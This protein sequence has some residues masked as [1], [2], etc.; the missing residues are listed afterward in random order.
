MISIANH[1]QPLHLDAWTNH[2]AWTNP[3][4][5]TAMISPIYRPRILPN[6][7]RQTIS[8][9]SS[10]GARHP[11]PAA[12]KWSHPPSASIVAD[13][14]IANLANKSLHALSLADLVK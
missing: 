4:N 7:I 12:Y 14:E 9:S 2:T 11:S 3:Q 10:N 6:K 8:R 5:Q 13:D 1:T